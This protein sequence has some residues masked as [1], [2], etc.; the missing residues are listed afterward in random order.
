MRQSETAD[1][2]S[3][4]S[5]LSNWLFHFGLTPIFNCSFLQ[6]RSVQSAKI[7]ALAQ[8]ALF[9]QTRSKGF[10]FHIALKEWR[11]APV[12]VTG[13]G[14]IQ[15][16]GC[17]FSWVCCRCQTGSVVVW[18]TVTSEDTEQW[19]EVETLIQAWPLTPRSF[20]ASL[21]H[22]RYCPL[23]WCYLIR[24]TTQMS[25]S[26]PFKFF[27]SFMLIFYNHTYLLHT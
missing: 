21:V 16:C 19:T 9:T 10:G 8:V 15:V 23:G 6:G 2:L 22:G 13:T 1:V 24:W 11:K 5:S 20:S 4:K 18:A 25:D 3:Q 12:M 17:N 7:W 26:L 27:S 14:K